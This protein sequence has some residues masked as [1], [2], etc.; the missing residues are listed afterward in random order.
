MC[1][2]KNIINILRAE[3]KSIRAILVI[4]LISIGIDSNSQTLTIDSITILGLTRTSKEIVLRDLIIKKGDT[5]SFQELPEIKR[6]NQFQLL[7]QGIF[8]AV[9][10]IPSISKSNN[11]KV[12]FDIYITEALYFYPV[13]Y[14]EL[15]DRNFN[16]WWKEYKRDFSR[17]NL[18]G[19]LY[20]NN[21]TGNRDR[22]DILMQW[23]YH[24][25]YEIEYSL[26]FINKSKTLGFQ[27]SGL[28]SKTREIAYNT[29]E[30]NKQQRK[31]SERTLLK[32]F[33]GSLGLI[34]QPKIRLKQRFLF[35]WRSYIVDSSVLNSLN[36]QFLITDNYKLSYPAFEYT[37]QYDK[38]NIKPHPSGGYLIEGSIEKQ[39]FN[40]FRNALIGKV[41]I[42]DYFT[43]VPGLVLA[44]Q[45]RLQAN[46]MKNKTDYYHN[47]ALG[48]DQF[49]IRSYE[50]YL[51]D[52]QQYGYLKS[53]LQWLIYDDKWDLS[54]IMP[55]DALKK[56]PIQVF[57]TL[58]NDLGYVQQQKG[59]LK[60]Q[61]NNR[62]L[63][64]GGVGIDIVIYYDK[65]IQLE[66]SFNQIFENDLFL[67][68][69]LNF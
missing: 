19:K 68:A 64:G 50:Y 58:N 48:E 10:I 44:E 33:K 21:L 16:V 28:W 35:E 61:F 12:N 57:L 5:I 67:H 56:A 60:G 13:P 36:E 20:F 41:E 25:K 30:E 55:F 31:L 54:G 59:F 49:Y 27:I 51:I 62:V 22:L 52:G 47:R 23:G 53:S 2:S 42:K 18:G 7:N 14:L 6:D 1:F 4:I 66:Y 38:R 37:I 17:I 11:R 9:E 26:P 45:F 15:V 3:K 46:L 43:L 40:K 34:Y 29:T 39:G 32:R 24:T 65:V 69:N 63:W 8:A